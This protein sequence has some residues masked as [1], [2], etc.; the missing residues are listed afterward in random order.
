MSTMLFHDYF[1]MLLIQLFFKAVPQFGHHFHGAGF[2]APFDFE[3]VGFTPAMLVQIALR[4]KG[5]VAV[6][7]GIRSLIGMCSDVLVKYTWFG[8]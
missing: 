1:G 7:T 5:N 2:N 6:Q 4:F 8:A 3:F